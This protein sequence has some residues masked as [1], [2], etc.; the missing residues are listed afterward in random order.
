MRRKLLIIALL[1]LLAALSGC[2]DRR[3]INDVVFVSATAVDRKDDKYQITIQFPL[4]GQM[5][6]AGS[7]GGGGGT[8][9]QKPWHTASAVGRTG[10][11]AN[12]E[13]QAS[14][15]RILNF[16]HRRVLILG[17][18][19]AKA[20]TSDVMDILGRIPQNRMS[21][22]VFVTEGEAHKLFKVD[23][24]LEKMPAELLREIAGM[25]YKRAR[26]IEDFV[27]A[28]LSEGIDP[29]LPYLAAVK[30]TQADNPD[31]PKIAML[32]GV[33]LFKGDKL[34]TVLKDSLAQGM[35][36]AL[37]QAK[38]PV[39]TV[40]APS[41][42]GFISLQ[43]SNYDVRISAS[44][45]SA[46]PSFRFVIEGK[47]QI[48]E[49]NSN[50]RASESAETIAGLERAVNLHIERVVREAF[51]ETQRHGVDPAGLGEFLYQHY[52][53]YWQRVKP[54]WRSVYGRADLSFHSRLEYQHPGTV[55]Y[56]VGIPEKELV[57]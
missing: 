33:A 18:E 43:A 25:T 34:E 55:T 49:N 21:A 15:S 50:F 2:W 51:A 46:A 16:S 47:L 7:G 56:P 40:K 45:G 27:D 9:G 31:A 1:P 3:E 11:E 39:I 32:K 53:R 17:E 19:A 57:P 13:Q 48:M 30:A 8:S 6:G 24:S 42:E 5:G 35:L 52:P 26:T 36:L 54:E 41:G 22:Y 37:N 23:S 20:G 4:P 28:I 14:L 12:A 44:P 10:R 29:Y 38:L